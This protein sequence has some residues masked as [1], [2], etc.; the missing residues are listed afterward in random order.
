MV[1][2]PSKNTAVLKPSSH[3][4]LHR[5]ALR[6]ASTHLW[7]PSTN[8]TSDIQYV[9]A[10]GVSLLH[11]CTT[12]ELQQPF[13]HTAI[14]CIT[15]NVVCP[16]RNVHRVLSPLPH[17]QSRHRH[18]ISKRTLVIARCSRGS[19]NSAACEGSRMQLMVP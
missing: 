15:V 19:S 4:M 17:R 3:Q 11:P 6:R 5:L 7:C 10:K 16:H 13:H 1:T 9:V 12:N 14:P 8:Q 18:V 2:R